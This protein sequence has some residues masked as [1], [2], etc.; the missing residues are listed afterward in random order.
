MTQI[1]KPQDI[2]I[3]LKIVCMK[4][5]DWNQQILA[6]SLYVSQS[7]ISQSLKRSR[8]AG[9]LGPKKDFVLGNSLLE[10][11][12]FGLKYVFPQQPGRVVK[13][14][15]TAHSMTPLS[16]EILSNEH[17]VWPTIQGNV[18]GHAIQPL[19]PNVVKAVR[20]DHQLYELL[21]M[22]D[23]IRVGRAR[24]REMAIRILKDRIC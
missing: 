18:R 8:Y 11:I 14:M 1:M 9:L 13:G 15:P 6:S 16:E 20:E 17:Y 5:H 12:E 21:A 22:V 4:N 2:V 19:Y 24:E 10:F 23:A 3:L 7:E